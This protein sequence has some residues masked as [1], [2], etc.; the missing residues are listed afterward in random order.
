MERKVD[1]GGLARKG[2][3]KSSKLKTGRQVRKKGG[4]ES[5]ARNEENKSRKGGISE[6]QLRK[7]GVRERW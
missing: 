5:A 2:G 7:D 1:E 6:G 4:K 3:K